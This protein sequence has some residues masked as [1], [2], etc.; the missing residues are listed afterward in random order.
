MTNCSV[1]GCDG[2]HYGRGF[3]RK[4]Y[5]QE[6]THG[7]PSVN[8]RTQRTPIANRFWPKVSKSDGCWEW[9]GCCD[10]KGYG[11]IGTGGKHGIDYA[12]RVSYEMHNGP[13]PEGLHVLHR[14]DNPP[15]VRP[16]HLFIGTHTDNMQDMWAKGRGK[17]DGAGRKGEANGNHKL[18]D[19]QVTEIRSR[20]LNGES[21]RSLGREYGVSKTMVGLIAKGTARNN[22]QE[23]KQ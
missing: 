3:C 21:Q 15:C 5:M 4:H 7:D 13:I 6:R 23:S 9:T 10:S 18:T 22:T 19:G 14:C 1:A 8:A 12:H 2:K 17:C 11:Q 20:N 16:D